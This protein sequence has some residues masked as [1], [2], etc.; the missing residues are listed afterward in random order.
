MNSN[1]VIL[2]VNASKFMRNYIHK[3]LKSKNYKHIIEAVDGKNAIDALMENKVDLI[4]T[5]LNMPKVN[6]LELVKALSNH[7]ELKYIPIMVIKS[8]DSIEMFEEAMKLGVCDY[9]EKPFTPSE[10][11]L[12]VNAIE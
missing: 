6:G 11:E 9:L 10:I 7:S 2:V 1:S 5:D 3:S 4:I 8:D 12:K